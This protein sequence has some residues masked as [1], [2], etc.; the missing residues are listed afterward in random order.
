MGRSVWIFDPRGQHAQ[1]P[2]RMRSEQTS[3]SLLRQ[4]AKWSVSGDCT[5]GS[6]WWLFGDLE[7]PETCTDHY[8]SLS[9]YSLVYRHWPLLALIAC[10]S[11]S[12]L[13]S[14]D[15]FTERER[16]QLNCTTQHKAPHG[17]FLRH[18]TLNLPQEQYKVQTS[19][20][21]AHHVQSDVVDKTGV[22]DMWL[23]IDPAT[24][25]RNSRGLCFMMARF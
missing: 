8:L 24:A 3:H 19:S 17:G 1:K 13:Y 5:T 12:V 2:L 23:K 4:L 6:S 22:A 20:P 14:A 21:V 18:T 7:G 10:Y 15:Y 9:I 16:T 11:A 25:T